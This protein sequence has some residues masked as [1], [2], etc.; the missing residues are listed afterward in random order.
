MLNLFFHFWL[1]FL[2]ILHLH[3]ADFQSN[4]GGTGAH[5]V[6]QSV[7]VQALPTPAHTEKAF[8]WWT[9]S[10]MQGRSS[11][12]REMA[13]TVVPWKKKSMISLM[14]FMF[15][16]NNYFIGSRRVSRS[17]SMLLLHLPSW[18]RTTAE[19]Q[20]NCCRTFWVTTG[21]SYW[22]ITFLQPPGSLSSKDKWDFQLDIS[23]LLFLNIHVLSFHTS[24]S[25]SFLLL[26]PME[27]DYLILL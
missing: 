5:T 7:P 15:N 2:F 19:I 25:H 8:S 21:P 16:M 6:S 22:K 17:L 3:S 9:D 14:W 27:S 20:M 23:I 4:R 12:D 10:K 11:F 24:Q 18:T 13:T 1:M 26:A